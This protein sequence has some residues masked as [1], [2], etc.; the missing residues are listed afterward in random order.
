MFSVDIVYLL[1]SI[2]YCILYITTY[3]TSYRCC[4]FNQWLRK[5]MEAVTVKQFKFLRMYAEAECFWLAASDWESAVWK[6][7]VFWLWT[8]MWIIV[9]TVG[10]WD[11]GWED[12]WWWNGAGIRRVSVC[13]ERNMLIYFAVCKPKTVLL[14]PHD[15]CS[16]RDGI[17]LPCQAKTQ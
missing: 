13:C 8:S 9:D 12:W 1:Y 17:I 4:S 10:A 11:Q 6:C 5:R 3:H 16:V 14:L 15:V 2:L 7:L